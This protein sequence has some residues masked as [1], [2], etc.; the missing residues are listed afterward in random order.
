VSK[1]PYSATDI[2]SHLRRESKLMLWLFL[3]IPVGMTAAVVALGSWLMNH[4]QIDQCLD[5]RGDYNQQTKACEP[6][7]K[8]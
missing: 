6:D 1:L 4:L 3:G 5:S 2:S 7:V 8:K